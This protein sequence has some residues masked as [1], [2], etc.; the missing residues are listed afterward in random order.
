MARFLRLIDEKH[1]YAYP[2]VH[3]LNPGELS[4]DV[5]KDLSTTHGD[6]SLYDISQGVT[7]ERVA[8]AMAATRPSVR[9]L[10]YVLFDDSVLTTIGLPFKQTPGGTPDSQVNDVHY[11]AQRITTVKLSDLAHKLSETQPYHID[12]G[13]VRQEL[14]NGLKAGDLNPKKYFNK[15]LLEELGMLHLRMSAD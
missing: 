3:W 13:S 5:L 4:A 6:L 10:D 1:W 9:Y 14:L 2:D 11:D 15:N 8:I 7:A 12:K